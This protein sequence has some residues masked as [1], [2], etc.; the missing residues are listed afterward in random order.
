MS[1]QE[2]RN[3]L[4]KLRTKWFLRGPDSN[5]TY[6]GS[7][8]CRKQAEDFPMLNRRSISNL[9][10][11]LY[12][13]GTIALGVIGLVWTDFANNWQRVPKDLPYREVFAC[14]AALYELLGGAAIL[15]RRTARV[16]AMMLALLYAVFCL[17]VGASDPRV[18][19][20][21]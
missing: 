10:I 11:Y 2:T 6:P 18:S 3:W 19:S 4:H 5:L 9:G 14:A 12:A 13:V 20:S 21:V 8:G 15:W 1:C 16:G 17:L 7:F